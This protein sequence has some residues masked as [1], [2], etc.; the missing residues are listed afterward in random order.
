MQ[1]TDYNH[2]RKFARTAD[3]DASVGQA[4]TQSD[5]FDIVLSH[6][7]VPK[8][9]EKLD[10]FH[11]WLPRSNLSFPSCNQSQDAGKEQIVE[12]KSK[13]IFMI[14][15]SMKIPFVLLRPIEIPLL[16]HLT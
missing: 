12:K 16:S 1:R 6:G 11:Q 3:S 5:N 4:R 13:I 10:S 8:V 9:L 2:R 7:L 14:I 15:W